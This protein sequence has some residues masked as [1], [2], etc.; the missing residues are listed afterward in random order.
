[1][2]LVRFILFCLL[3]AVFVPRVDGQTFR[4]AGTE[5]EAIRQIV[6]P[7]EKSLEIGV[8]EFH[9]HGLLRE[10]GKNVLVLTIDR[11]PTPTRVLQQGPGDFCRVAFQTV[12]QQREFL[13]VYGGDPPKPN[14]VPAW[15]SRSGLLLETREYRQCNLNNFESVKEAFEGSK[16]IGS[17]Y[18]NSVEHGS[19]PFTLTPAPFLSRYTG[20]LNIATPGKY[21]FLTSSEDCSFLLVDDQ[22]VVSAPGRHGP[23]RRA[24]PG[25]RNDIQL[26]Q[27]AHKFEYYHAASGP[28]AMMVAV[29]EPDPRN[30]KPAPISIPPSVFRAESAGQVHVGPPETRQEKLLPHFAAEITGSV[31]LPDNPQHLLGVQFQNLSPPALLTKSRMLWDFGDGQNSDQPS[32]EHVFLRPGVYPVTLSI[33]RGVKKVEISYTLQIDQRR[34]RPKDLHELDRYL[35]IVETYEPAKLDTASLQQLVLAYLWKSE[36]IVNPRED[37]QQETAE[38][39]DETVVDPAEE[40]RQLVQR[41]KAAAE[42]LVRAVEAAKVAFVEKSAAVGDEPLFELAQLAAPI[43]RDQLGDSR[44]AGQIW[45]GAAQRISRSDLRAECQLA[46]ADIALNDLLLSDYAKGLLDKASVAIGPAATGNVVPLLYRIWGDYYAATGDRFQ[47]RKNYSDA[48]R[49]T[50][51]DRSHVEQIAWRGAHSRSTEQFLKSGRYGQAAQQLRAWQREFP[52]EKLEGYMHLLFARYWA[53]RENHAA[54]IAQAD[55]ILVVNPDSPYADRLLALAAECEEKRGQIDRAVAT[56]QSLL[57]D[58]RGS[59]LVPHIQAEVKRL[60]SLPKK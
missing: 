55:Q 34:D 2:R 46:A 25:S 56:L 1:M 44:L 59:P 32:P 8:A 39:T 12:G 14:E 18:V 28:S 54:A 4:H 26:D 16:Q 23:E 19:N 38:A 42:Y 50:Q 60:E 48:D 37:D 27:G 13:L 43:A 10:D 6:L 31:P 24:R 21:G 52:G 53:G 57:H 35:P 9:H 47:A 22:V 15:T 17:G 41:E 5:F 30:E 49:V 11:K 40:T 33:Q 51:S 36:L 3:T 58:Y 20:A 29:W 7:E 45:Q